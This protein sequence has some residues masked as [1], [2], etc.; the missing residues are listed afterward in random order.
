MVHRNDLNVAF[1]QPHELDALTAAYDSAWQHIC[2]INLGMTATPAS[3]LKK[4]LAQIILA[5]ACTGEC[6]MERLREIALRGVA[7]DRPQRNSTRDL[8]VIFADLSPEHPEEAG[9]ISDLPLFFWPQQ[10][11]DAAVDCSLLLNRE[12]IDI[13]QR[14]MNASFSLLRKLAGAKSLSEIAHLQAAHLSNQ[15]AALLGQTDEVAALCMTAMKQL[16]PRLKLL[17]R[18]QGAQNA[19]P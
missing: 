1:F 16:S 17:P 11:F 4:K 7:L 8:N 9:W 13:L 14:H 10:A 18:A 3:L 6:D 2:D 15:A 19:S 5:S 12:M